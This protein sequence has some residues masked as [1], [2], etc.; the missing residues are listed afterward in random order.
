MNFWLT[1]I[2]NLC[3]LL[4]AIAGSIRFSKINRVYYP[5]IYC[6]WLGL[7]IEISSDILAIYYSYSNAAISNIYVLAESLLITWQFNNWKL[8][9][10]RKFIFQLII[11]IFLVT[12]ILDNLVISRINYISSYFRILYSFVIVMMS[13]IIINRLIVTERKNLLKNSVFLVSIGFVFY[14]TLKIIVEAFWVYGVNDKT[15][16]NNVYN[17]SIIANFLTNLLYTVAI[18]WMPTKQRFTLPSW[19][20]RSL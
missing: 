9:E 6:I 2:L 7:I 4:P 1:V 14:Y 12:W 13:I 15:F 5:F 16:S 19:S 10:K 17:I 18:L 3:I 8:F 20:L 11:V